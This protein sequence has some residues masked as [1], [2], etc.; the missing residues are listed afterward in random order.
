MEPDHANTE[1]NEGAGR[2]KQHDGRLGSND[3][4]E[5]SSR[6]PSRPESPHGVPQRPRER[7]RVRFNSTSEVNDEVNQRFTFPLQDKERTLSAPA[8]GVPAETASPPSHTRPPLIKRPSD[9]GNTLNL[10]LTSNFGTGPPRRPPALRR[11]TAE[12]LIQAHDGAHDDSVEDLPEKLFSALAAQKRGERMATLVGSSSA[13]TSP[14]E[15]LDN[16]EDERPSQYHGQY[17]VRIDDIPLVALGRRP[18]DSS[19][20]E[21]EDQSEKP[22]QKERQSSE[23]HRLVRAYTKRDFTRRFRVPNNTSAGLVSGQVTPVDERD[24]EEDYVARP[25]EFRGGVLSALL[26]LHQ[27]HGSQSTIRREDTGGSVASP[28]SE[29]P[30]P[31]HS[32]SNSPTRKAQKWYKKDNHSTNTLAGL[33]EASAKLSAPAGGEASAQATHRPAS[34]LSAGRRSP[35]ARL[36]GSIGKRHSP[37]LED[38]IRITVHIAETIS[39]Q[40]Y[41]VKLCKALMS[42]GAPTHRLEEYLKMS[43]RVLEL[44]SQF[45]YLPGCMIIAFDDSS[46]HTTEVKLIRANQG[47]DLG[48]LKDVHAIYKEVVH[49]CIGVEEATQRLDCVIRKRQKNNVWFLVLVYGFASATVGPFAFQARLIDMPICFVLGCILGVLQLVLAPKSELYSNVFEISAAVIMSFIARAFGSILYREN[50]L[51]CFS[52]MVQSSIAL[53]LPGYIILC[54]ALELQ[55]RSILAGSVRIVY[56]IIYSLFLGYGI[57]VGSAIYGLIDQNATSA[58]TCSNTLN[59]YWTFLF[60]PIFTLCLCVINQ[61]KWKQIPVMIAIAQVGYTVNFFA[62]RKFPASNQISSTLG[63]LS[64]GVLGNLYSRTRHGLAAAAL[65]P[66][67]FVQVPSGLAASGSLLSGLA[68]ADQLTGSY[69]Y[70]NGT[71]KVNSTSSVSSLEP[72]VAKEN[73]R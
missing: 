65:L 28:T 9:T 46:T 34:V 21:D 44:E 71:A 51:F 62:S 13:P 42:Y 61:A 69:T 53:I 25:K 18:Y 49:D 36:M 38:E 64:V 70:A 10:G 14:R 47:V 8:L 50:T 26:R 33:V 16:S 43:A 48:K 73:A 56:A 59:P 29:S 4:S 17:P 12:S 24:R 60:V 19:D 40:K 52:A 6:T 7:A 11:S 57:T 72:M 66:A 68:T 45:L 32:R 30:T 1:P 5:E 41:L 2:D 39:R 35:A 15:S 20:D 63:S 3:Y 27:S 23:A 54:G 22:L 37:R 58:T 55:S 67:I 31:A